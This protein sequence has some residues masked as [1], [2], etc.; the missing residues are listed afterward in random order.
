MALEILIFPK[1]E[2]PHPEAGMLA[3]KLAFEATTRTLSKVTFLVKPVEVVVVGNTARKISPQRQA[4][5][6]ALEALRKERAKMNGTQPIV[7]S[8]RFDTTETVASTELKPGQK[9][10]IE[11]RKTNG[12]LTVI[13]VTNHPKRGMWIVT[14]NADLRSF[15]AGQYPTVL[16]IKPDADPVAITPEPPKPSLLQALEIMVNGP[17]KSQ[18][19]TFGATAIIELPPVLASIGKRIG[20]L[21]PDDFQSGNLPT[22]QETVDAW[23]AGHIQTPQYRAIQ[24]ARR[25]HA[26]PEMFLTVEAMVNETA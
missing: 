17:E 26:D 21:T 11:S 9:F 7:R 20:D 22:F 12:I 25:I 6:D 16:R 15:H 3:Q 5:I 24:D 14:N 2:P 13:T 23:N 4:E 18:V 1:L 19:I 8:T 10:S